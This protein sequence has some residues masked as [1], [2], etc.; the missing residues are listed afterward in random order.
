MVELNHENK[1]PIFILQADAISLVTCL[2]TILSLQCSQEPGFN[3]IK[4]NRTLQ[5]SNIQNK[6]SLFRLFVGFISWHFG[7]ITLT[8]E[9]KYSTT[10]FWYYRWSHGN[11]LKKTTKYTLK[12]GN[13]IYDQWIYEWYN[14]WK[15][16]EEIVW[17]IEKLWFL[18][19]PILQNYCR[20]S[21]TGFSIWNIVVLF[22]FNI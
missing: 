14:E 9:D 22:I 10:E 3:F 12:H 18:L 15:Q 21:F 1:C 19:F 5:H 13:Y 17:E 2:I 20:T 7:E 16:W 6:N 4:Q 11:D 8:H